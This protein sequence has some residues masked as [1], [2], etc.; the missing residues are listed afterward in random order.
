MPTAMD[1]INYYIN[2]TDEQIANAMALLKSI[3][4]MN[5]K[6]TTVEKNED[7]MEGEEIPVTVKTDEE[8]DNDDEK[9][10][11]LQEDCNLA[12]DLAS[13]EDKLRNNI[14]K[15][16]KLNREYDAFVDNYDTQRNAFTD[17]YRKLFD[18]KTRILE[19]R[20]KIY[21]TWCEKY[22]KVTKT[23]KTNT[24]TT[25]LESKVSKPKIPSTAKILNCLEIFFDDAFTAADPYSSLNKLLNGKAKT[26]KFISDTCDYD[27]YDIADVLAKGDE[28]K[29]SDE[30]RALADYY[31]NK[32]QKA[33]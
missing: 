15:F 8:I 14:E 21:K 17:E 23:A 9:N 26:V 32:K 33:K 22:C 12:N 25:K 29:L 18:E 11:L 10:R 24:E 19:A 6:S 27:L 31:G 1:D 13:V 2:M 30:V 5:A 3:D 20:E 4:E 28:A 16:T 7:D